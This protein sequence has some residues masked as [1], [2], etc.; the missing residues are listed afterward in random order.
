MSWKTDGRGLGA[1]PS[2]AYGRSRLAQGVLTQDSNNKLTRVP[3]LQTGEL[4]SGVTCSGALCDGSIYLQVVSLA[5]G[6]LK[7]V[8]GKGIGMG[9]GS[10]RSGEYFRLD[11][12]NN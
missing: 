12:L 5:A 6:L 4:C 9:E 2:E 8:C 3:G 7:A 11:M 10:P 1:C